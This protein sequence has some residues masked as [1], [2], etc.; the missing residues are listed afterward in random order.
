MDH[1]VSALCDGVRRQRL[2]HESGTEVRSRIGGREAS[3]ANRAAGHGSGLLR[4][5]PW[6]LPGHNSVS[7]HVIAPR[8]QRRAGGNTYLKP[9]ACR[10]HS[11]PRSD[12]A[13]QAR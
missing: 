8:G 6:R 9:A 4:P 11:R 13:G 2:W 12:G 1:Q 3:V 5:V 10:G 7:Q